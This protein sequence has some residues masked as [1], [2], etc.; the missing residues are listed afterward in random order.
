VRVKDR[1]CAL[2]RWTSQRAAEWRYEDRL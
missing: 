1:R 2:F